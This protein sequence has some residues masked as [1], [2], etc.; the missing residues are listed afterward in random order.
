MAVYVNSACR[1]ALL[2]VHNVPNRAILQTFVSVRLAD[3]SSTIGQF[4]TLFGNFHRNESF[5]WEQNSSNSGHV[6]ERQAALYCTDLNF[7]V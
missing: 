7:K 6:F 4:A 1:S 2:Y 5:G 3:R